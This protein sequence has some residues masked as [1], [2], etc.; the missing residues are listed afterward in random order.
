MRNKKL[1]KIIHRFAGLYHKHDPARRFKAVHQLFY[2]ICAYY[3]FAGCTA[4]YKPFDLGGG[5]VVNRNGKAL[6][7]HIH[8]QIFAHN[9]EAY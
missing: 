3:I 7:L 8:N 5:T 1:D 9:G 2:G 6:A 4:V